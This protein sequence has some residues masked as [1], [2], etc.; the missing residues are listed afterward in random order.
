MINVLYHVKY[1]LLLSRNIKIGF[2]EGYNGISGEEYTVVAIERFQ[3][4]FF[5]VYLIIIISM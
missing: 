1:S 5:R 3:T 2:G 4:V